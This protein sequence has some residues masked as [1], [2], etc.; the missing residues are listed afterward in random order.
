[1][2]RGIS[3]YEG[4]YEEYLESL[5]EDHLDATAILKKQRELDKEQAQGKKQTNSK[6][7]KKV[8][9]QKLNKEIKDVTKSIEQAEAEIAQIH[10]DWSDPEFFFSHT[11]VEIED[12]QAREVTLKGKL[13]E[14]MKT[15]EQLE[16]AL[17]EED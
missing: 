12:M 17:G 15:W 5:G 9:R 8:N 14:W 1:M 16:S 4:N 2:E 7:T 3:L 13:E 10:T 11:Q 6:K